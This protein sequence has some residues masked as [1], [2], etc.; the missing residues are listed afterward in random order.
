MDSI[1]SASFFA[2]TAAEAVVAIDKEG[3]AAI[4]MGYGMGSQTYSRATSVVYFESPDEL[5]K[6][7]AQ[8]TEAL[9]EFDA[10][11]GAVA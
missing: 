11:T 1:T 8:A 4:R 10:K 6:F 9:R 2:V 3:E 7:L 5:R